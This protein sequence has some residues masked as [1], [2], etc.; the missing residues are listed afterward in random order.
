M[1]FKIEFCS[2]QQYLPTKRH[3]KI[4]RRYE[5]HSLDI[6]IIAVDN[7]EFPVAFLVTGENMLPREIRTYGGKLYKAV[8]K[9]NALSICDIINVELT[10][11]PWETSLDKGTQRKTTENELPSLTQCTA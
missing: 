2:N 8:K 1:K 4:R 7:S 10:N 3:K 5:K 6:E 9:P 11:V